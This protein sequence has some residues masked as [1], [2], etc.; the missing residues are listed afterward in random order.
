[1]AIRATTV[2]GTNIRGGYEVS[3]EN[4]LVSPA[5]K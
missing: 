4:P 3:S 5:H 2:E 1:M